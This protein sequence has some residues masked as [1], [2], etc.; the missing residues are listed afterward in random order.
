MILPCLH[1]IRAIVNI[2]AGRIVTCCCMPDSATSPMPI[3]IDAA[4]SPPLITRT[5]FLH[6]AANLSD[7]SGDRCRVG[8]F[9]SPLRLRWKLSEG[10]LPAVPHC[11]STLSPEYAAGH[12]ERNSVGAAR[13]WHW[14]RNWND[15]Y[16]MVIEDPNNPG[17]LRQIT[18]PMLEPVQAKKTLG[19]V[20]QL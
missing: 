16:C 20:V 15:V 2:A 13:G 6:F 9:P 11:N 18:D 7:A 17:K 1:C 8:A 4:C 12:I 5:R 3:A 14:Q 19:A 10:C